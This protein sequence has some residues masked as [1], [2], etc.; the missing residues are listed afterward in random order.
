MSIKLE[1]NIVK[2]RATNVYNFVLALKPTTPTL[3]C[4]IRKP[5]SISL[6]HTCASRCSHSEW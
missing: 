4:K 3:P 5:Y 2:K 1:G 6:Q